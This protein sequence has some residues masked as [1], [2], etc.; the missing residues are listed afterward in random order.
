MS[1]RLRNNLFAASIVICFWIAFVIPSAVKAAD[2][3]ITEST[4]TII[5]SGDQTTTVKSPPPSAIASQITS[6]SSDFICTTSASGAIQTQILGIS[7]GAMHTNELCELLTKST[8]LYN[9]G[10]KVAA[11]SVLCEDPVI[12]KAMANSG[13]FCPYKTLLGKDA[14]AAWSANQHEI[15]KELDEKNKQE[16]RDTY[17]KYIAGIAAA[18]LFF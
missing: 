6:G 9:M 10:M 17:I 16:E 7:L 3:I 2:P 18:F 14:E 15:P 13:T 12:H 1:N 4:Q 5:S 8:A 11:I